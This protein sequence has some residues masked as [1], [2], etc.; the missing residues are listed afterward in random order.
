MCALPHPNFAEMAN[1]LAAAALIEFGHAER[2]MLVSRDLS[3]VLSQLVG[4]NVTAA[5][6]VLLVHVSFGC[7]CFV[8]EY[9]F[10]VAVCARLS[11]CMVGP[12]VAA[13]FKVFFVRVSFGVPAL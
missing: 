11:M 13:A 4:P 10:A 9:V 12:N 7:A 3:K 8:S 6:K 1:A 2:L 5:F